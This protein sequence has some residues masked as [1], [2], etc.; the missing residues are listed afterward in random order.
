MAFF[1]NNKK[2]IT[3]LNIDGKPADEEENKNNED[4]L[5]EEPTPTDNDN[6]GGDPDELDEEP[7]PTDGGDPDE[8]D[9]EPTPIDNNEGEDNNEPTGGDYNGGGG[10]SG[11]NTDTSNEIPSDGEESD[12]SNGDTEGNEGS[13]NGEEL[14]EPE[15]EEGSEEGEP[16]GDGTSNDQS[17]KSMEDE[18]FSSL[19]EPQKLIKISELKG[20]FSKLYRSCDDVFSKI[21]SIPRTDENLLVLERITNTL[22][23][24]KVYIEHYLMYTFDTKTYTENEV[25]L[26]KYISIFNA[27][28]EIFKEISIQKAKI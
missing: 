21:D 14:E 25:N 12:T 27:V 20:S 9:Q 5:D 19:S 2:Y 11:A 23:D 24:L 4:E 18:I 10:S 3:E 17:I 26:Q 6:E 8:L 1:Y 22:S 15:P 13:D 16:T 7:T 28:K